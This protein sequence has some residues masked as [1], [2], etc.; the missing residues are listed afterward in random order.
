MASFFRQT[1]MS[2]S[3]E[4]FS[5]EEEPRKPMQRLTKSAWR[6]EPNIVFENSLG[7][8]ESI[9]DAF[10]DDDSDEEELLRKAK[11]RLLTPE[12]LML[13]DEYSRCYFLLVWMSGLQQTQKFMLPK[14]ALSELDQSMLRACQGIVWRSSGEGCAKLSLCEYEALRYV[15]IAVGCV[16]DFPSHALAVSRQLLREKEE[17][18]ETKTSLIDDEAKEA[19]QSDDALEKQETFE[20]LYREYLQ[21][22]KKRGQRQRIEFARQ[23]ATEW[24]RCNLRAPKQD[25]WLVHRA[26]SVCGQCMLVVRD[27]SFVSVFHAGVLSD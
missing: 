21:E 1:Q 4:S 20:A 5:L 2:E 10:D 18:D 19:S 22:V 27:K 26:A 11:R 13:P 15:S 25:C 7:E 8:S 3:D 23:D 17:E 16:L 6:N 12:D 24:L 9:G 14:S